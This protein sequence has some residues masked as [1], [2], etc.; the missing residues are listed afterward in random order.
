MWSFSRYF[1]HSRR[2]RRGFFMIS[3]LIRSLQ[4]W[5]LSPLKPVIQ[6]YTLK[7]EQLLSTVCGLREGIKKTQTCKQAYALAVKILLNA[8]FELFLKLCR[9]HPTKWPTYLSLDASMLKHKKQENLVTFVTISPRREENQ[10]SSFL[11][12]KPK[13]NSTQ[14]KPTLT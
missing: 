4:G 9:N 12:S 3:L 7:T 14:L 11:L 6:R 2:V 13:P 1:K 10:T 8:Q 5:T